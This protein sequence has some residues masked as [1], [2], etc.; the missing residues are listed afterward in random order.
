MTD[1]PTGPPTDDVAGYAEPDTGEM[2]AEDVE[3]MNRTLPM[4][5]SFLVVPLLIV[6]VA[7][8][9]LLAFGMTAYEDAEPDEFVRILQSGNANRRWQAAFELAKQINADPER[10][11]DQGLGP[12]LVRVFGDTPPDSEDNRT[13]RQYLALCLGSLGD[14]VAI[15]ALR[16]AVHDPDS[17]TRI[18]VITALGQLG[19]T[20]AAPDLIGV[21]DE[22]DAGVVKAAAYGLGAMA[23]PGAGDALAGLLDHATADVRWNAAVSLAKLHDHRATPVLREM[24]RRDGVAAVPGIAPDQIQSVMTSAIRSAAALRIDGLRPTLTE[25]AEHD[26]D[27]RVRDAAFQALEALRAGPQAGTRSPVASA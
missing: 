21:L 2:P 4:I 19:A 5:L 25:L 3:A 15:P 24:L 6:I 8:G 9:V 26:P 22:D 13:V 10:L 7:V 11:R 12:S 27:L 1:E 14:P 16:A 23:S 17:T 18:Y 20:E